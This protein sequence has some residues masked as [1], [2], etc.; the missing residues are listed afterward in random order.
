MQAHAQLLDPANYE[1]IE[2]DLTWLGVAGL[3]D[4]PR[5]EVRG[6]IEDCVLGSIRVRTT[7]AADVIPSVQLLAVSRRSA[8]VQL[9][10]SVTLNSMKGLQCCQ[11]A[12][13]CTA[14]FFPYSEQHGG[15][16][17][18]VK[19]HLCEQQLA[20][21]QGVHCTKRVGS[22]KAHSTSQ[23]PVKAYDYGT[24]IMH[25][26]KGSSVSCTCKVLAA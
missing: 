9:L 10:S 4:P 7:S 6:A 20:R 21:W 26:I 1:S 12:F 11:T 3:L 24:C 22:C 15:S 19:E 23:G 13:V 18:G 2:S 16:A 5:P 14:L 17:G 8:S 25:L